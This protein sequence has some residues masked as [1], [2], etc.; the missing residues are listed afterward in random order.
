MSLVDSDEDEEDDLEEDSEE[1]KGMTWEELERGAC[2]ANRGNMTMKLTEKTKG[3][4]G[5]SK[6]LGSLVNQNKGGP[7]P[8][9]QSLGKKKTI[10]KLWV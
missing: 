2:N 1:V 4:G 8:K 6:P 3:R 9:D 5:K 7:I 10:S